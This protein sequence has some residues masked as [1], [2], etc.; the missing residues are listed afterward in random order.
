MWDEIAA[1]HSY[2]GDVPA[3]IS[4]LKVQEEAGEAAEALIGMHGWNSRKGICATRDDVLDELADVIITAAV[5]MCGIAP[6]DAAAREHFA[7]RLSAVA[8]RAA[9]ARAAAP[10]RRL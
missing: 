3:E 7:R 9:P 5:A 8:E 10:E 6:S 4:V 2:H 1:L